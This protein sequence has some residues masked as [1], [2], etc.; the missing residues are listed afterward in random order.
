M[1]RV[2]VV[3]RGGAGKSTLAERLGAITGLRVVHLDD[4]FWQSGLVA[5]QR[6]R[7]TAVQRDLITEPTWIMEGDLGPRDVLDV[8]LEAADTVVMLDLSC[9]RCAWRAMRRSRERAD[10]W[11]RLLTYRRRSRP[12]VMEAIATRRRRSQEVT[13]AFGGD[14]PAMSDA[15]S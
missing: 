7:W 8:R 10:F 11:H 13:T 12:L 5:T 6:D 1:K 3:G 2:V 4:L 15:V 9:V 14:S